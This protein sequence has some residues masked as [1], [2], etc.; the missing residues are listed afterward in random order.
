MYHQSRLFSVSRGADYFVEG[1][2]LQLRS[3]FPYRQ[4]LINV[5]FQATLVRVRT[6]AFS[7]SRRRL[8]GRFY[9]RIKRAQRKILN[10][11]KKKKKTKGNGKELLS[12][13]SRNIATDT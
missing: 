11:R 5:T 4:P 12:L 9:K 3:R 13:P 8:K 1:V 6:P 2:R 10:F 7:E